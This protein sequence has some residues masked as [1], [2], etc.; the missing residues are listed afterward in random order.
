VVVVISV[1]VLVAVT[2]VNPLGPAQLYES[3][4]PEPVTA[5]AV[6]V[7]SVPMHNKEEDAVIPAIVGLALTVTAGAVATGALVQPLP[8]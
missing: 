7:K 3:K 5:P 6:N 8:G 2:S 1:E 4:D